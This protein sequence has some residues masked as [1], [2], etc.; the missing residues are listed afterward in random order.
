MRYK[1]DI[2]ELDRVITKFEM[3][4]MNHG[5]SDGPKIDDL[6]VRHNVLR[7]IELLCEYSA[8]LKARK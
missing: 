3:I 5:L 7:A 8:F 2:R 4:I 1:K 6:D